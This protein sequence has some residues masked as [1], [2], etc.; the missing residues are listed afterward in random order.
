MGFNL[1]FSFSSD[2]NCFI[3]VF[4]DG[5]K[6]PVSKTRWNMKLVNKSRE[7]ESLRASRVLSSCAIADT[8]TEGWAA[9]PSTGHPESQNISMW[10]VGSGF[11]ARRRSLFYFLSSGD[12][13]RIIKEKKSVNELLREAARERIKA[14]K[15]L[16][17]ETPGGLQMYE[18]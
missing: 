8:T 4:A 2:Q 1:L 14:A 16:P 18:I 6:V 5:V 11:G 15:Y 7:A 9:G 13:M 3:P 10:G 12:K 17:T